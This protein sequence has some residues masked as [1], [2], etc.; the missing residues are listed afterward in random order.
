[1]GSGVAGAARAAPA[2]ANAGDCGDHSVGIESR[3]PA[4]AKGARRTPTTAER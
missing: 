3:R 4:G 1:M 2:S